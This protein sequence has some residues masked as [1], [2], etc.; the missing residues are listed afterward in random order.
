MSLLKQI[1]SE[2]LKARKEK[3][4]FTSGIL[5]TL[6]GEITAVG[7]NA[8]NRETTNEETQ[9][10]ITKFKKG[11]SDTIDLLLKNGKEVNSEEIL[12]LKKEVKIYEKFLPKMMSEKELENVIVNIISE[13]SD[14]NIGKIMGTLK[15]Q[16]SGQYDGK[17]A[18]QIA[19]NLIK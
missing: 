4:K 19:R 2:Q 1:K 17:T 12:N 15:S 16:Y 18:N 5:T 13:N 8:G 3:D 10:V 6:V 14:I 7:K 11:V 9:K